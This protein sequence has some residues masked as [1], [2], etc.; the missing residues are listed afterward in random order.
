VLRR[1]LAAASFAA[2][3]APKVA[4]VIDGGASL[5]LD[6][7]AADV[8]LRAAPALDGARLQVALGGDAAGATPIGAV[9][10]ADAAE[11]VIRLLETIAQAG[12]TARAHEMV[13]GGRQQ[14]FRDAVADLL[15]DAP[16]PRARGRSEPIGAYRLCDGR[17]ALGVGLTF[18]HTDAA[19]LEHLI[20][21]ARHAGAA[22]IRTAPGRALIIIGLTPNASASLAASAEGLGFITRPDDPRRQVV[23]CAGAPICGSAKIA[24]RALAPAISKTAAELLD[25]SVTIHIS[26][27]PKGCAHPAA[28]AL[29]LVGGERGCDLVA[30]GSARDRPLGAIPVEGLPAGMARLAHEIARAG[31]PG[32]R[33]ADTLARLG[34]A[35]LLALLGVPSHG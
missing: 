15:V 26:G 19:T 34:A 4:V 18:G 23:A 32:E 13:R 24:A 10:P 11:A 14:A 35:P 30:A 27:C 7:V 8:R 28:A 31:R 12:P 20:D 25:G 21:A 9:A 33:A 17:V 5:H 2:K 22:G 3:L 6:A 1:R 16:P 29:T